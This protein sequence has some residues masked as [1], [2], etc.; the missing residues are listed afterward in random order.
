MPPA[1]HPALQHA[2]EAVIKR[3]LFA[4]RRALPDPPFLL[5]CITQRSLPRPR[6]FLQRSTTRNLVKAAQ[7]GLETGTFAILWL[8]TY[9]FLLRLPSEALPVARGD[10]E[11]PLDGQSVFY[12]KDSTTVCLRLR[13]RTNRPK[14]SALERVCCCGAFPEMCPVHV[15]WHGFFA[16]L[17]HGVQP[18]AGISA[19]QAR[20]HLRLTLHKLKVLA[21]R[22]HPISHG[23]AMYL[24]CRMPSV[25]VLMTSGVGTRRQVPF[26]MFI[27]TFV[28]ENA[29]RS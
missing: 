5:P 23:C 1:A 17:A 24:R 16:H 19:T 27:H 28:I 26:S 2:K 18:W 10:A 11:L 20:E 4:A 7:T 12:L 14:G 25:T 9:V 21:F 15:L 29:I 8:M 22:S 13:S 3:M 6:M